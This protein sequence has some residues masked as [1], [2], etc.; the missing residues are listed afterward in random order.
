M[1]ALAAYL[2][3]EG[4]GMTGNQELDQVRAHKAFAPDLYNRAWELID[5]GKE[6]TDLEDEEMLLAAYGSAYHWHKLEGVIEE[7]RWK[8]SKPIAHDQ[9][10]RANSACSPAIHLPG[11]FVSL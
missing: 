9:L 5:K 7:A 2:M 3:S 1:P 6:R 11:L 8:Q 10:S 4:T